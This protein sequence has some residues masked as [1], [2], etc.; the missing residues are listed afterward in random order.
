[1]FSK[2][3]SDVH[4]ERFNDDSI[5]RVHHNTFEGKSSNYFFGV[6][7]FSSYDVKGMGIILKI[8]Y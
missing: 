8:N 7:T 1:M 4:R 5:K 2:L 6:Q 3:K